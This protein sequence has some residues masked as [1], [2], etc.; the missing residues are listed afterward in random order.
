[1]CFEQQQ[2]FSLFRLKLSHFD[3]DPRSQNVAN[4]MDPDPGAKI[5]RIPSL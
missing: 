3:Q 2:K 5:L 1:M 4:P